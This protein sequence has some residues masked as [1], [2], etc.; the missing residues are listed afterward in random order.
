MKAK[1]I[2]TGEIVAVHSVTMEE[3]TWKEINGIRIFGTRNIEVLPNDY[4]T[5]KDIDWEQRRFELVKAAIQGLSGNSQDII[6]EAN[7]EL[8]AT[9]AINL[10]D[11]VITKLRKGIDYG[12]RN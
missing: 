3:V 5:L 10:V 11:A 12:K 2:A 1:V 8:M 7:N 9:W 6:V 4:K